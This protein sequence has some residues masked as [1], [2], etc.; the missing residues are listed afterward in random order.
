MG[1]K[2]LYRTGKNRIVGGVAGGTADY[3]DIDPAIVRIIWLLSVFAAG[4]GLWAY[5]VAWAIVPENPKEKRKHLNMQSKIKLSKESM[6]HVSDGFHIKGKSAIFGL[7]LMIVGVIFLANN[8]FPE[9]RLDK[10]WPIIPIV[11][12]LAIIFSSYNHRK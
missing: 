9:L 11:V 8:F 12:G 5:L 4:A 6:Q 2:I 1:K 10:Y 3:L 7:G